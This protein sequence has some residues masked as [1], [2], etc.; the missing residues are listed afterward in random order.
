[1]SKR[2]ALYEQ[3][4]ALGGR[5]IEFGGWEMPVQYTGVMDE[6]LACRKSVGLFDVS[7]MGEFLIEGL[8]AERFLNEVVTN[9]I[10]KMAAGQA[11]YSA[12]CNDHGGIV[13]D[14][15]IYRRAVDR[16]LVVVNA[17]NTDK[18]F[19]WM[20]SIHARI[21]P[22]CLLENVSSK[23]SQIAVQGRNAEK[24]I[25][26]LA[27]C[28]LSDIQNYHFKEGTFLN[29]I[30][31]IFAR[32]GYT[33][34]DGFEL[35]VP[36]AK[37]P[38]VWKALMDAG[39]PYD[40]K[41]CGLGARDTLRLEMKYSL[42]GHELNDETNPLEAGLAWVTKLDKKS[43]I[44]KEALLNAKTQGISRRLIGFKMKDR[45]IPRQDYAVYDSAGLKKIGVVTSGTQSPSLNAA[46]GIAY[47]E[48]GFH[49][50]GTPLQ[51]E[52]RGNKTL[53]E[54]CTTPFYKRNK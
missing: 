28:S 14:L 41:A 4:V 27:S 52:I 11:M 12:M 22:D 49:E 1:M 5:I 18:D 7:H 8:D 45:G 9:D 29:S 23:Y 15:V 43:F 50:P 31:C 35:Y 44:G 21:H 37:G 53:A 39:K 48:V 24:L 10:S 19:N 2:T 54:V 38:E 47:V 51:I 33:G 3:H 30:D 46:I 16:F 34:E 32:T 13:D 36:W 17:S 6:H 25:E 42:Y 20:K 26:P 40:I